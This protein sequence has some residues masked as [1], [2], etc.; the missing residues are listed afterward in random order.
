M[1]TPQEISESLKRKYEAY[2]HDINQ[3]LIALNKVN[4]YLP[5]VIRQANELLKDTQAIFE[6]N[7]VVLDKVVEENETK[8]G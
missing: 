5:Q 4:H 8:T 2:A 1:K 6:L 7:K 3:L